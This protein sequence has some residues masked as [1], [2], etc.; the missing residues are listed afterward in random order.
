LTAG[1]KHQAVP[2]TG[3]SSILFWPGASTRAAKTHTD[4][5][6]PTS[7]PTPIIHKKAVIHKKISTTL[8]TLIYCNN[9]YEYS[10]NDVC[11][12]P[13]E[14]S[15]Y[16][17]ESVNLATDVDANPNKQRYQFVAAAANN[18]NDK[19]N[20]ISQV[21]RQRHRH[22]MPFNLPTSLPSQEEGHPILQENSSIPHSRPF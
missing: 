8:Q 5:I 17:Y 12:S 20:P 21:Q 1:I 13:D 9:S 11:N 15:S 19:A 16:H 22:G 18:Y 10:P 3:E 7:T 6:P 14:F 2:L 4:F